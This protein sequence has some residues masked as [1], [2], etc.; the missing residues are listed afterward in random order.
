MHWLA[1][2]LQRAA[3]DLV[4]PV[5]KLTDL[6]V[7]DLPAARSHLERRLRQAP[8]RESC[9]DCGSPL[10][11]FWEDRVVGSEPDHEQVTEGQLADYYME[12]ASGGGSN[13]TLTL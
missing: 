1:R 2:Q 8:Q 5:F 7:T 4:F 10:H 11:L 9:Q 3:L 12:L 13:W 6:A